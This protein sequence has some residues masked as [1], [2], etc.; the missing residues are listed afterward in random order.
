MGLG[1][2]GGAVVVIDGRMNVEKMKRGQRRDEDVGVEHD[3]KGRYSIEECKN[4]KRRNEDG[5]GW[6]DNKSE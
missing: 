4:K 2:G 6:A 1:G 3:G 5:R